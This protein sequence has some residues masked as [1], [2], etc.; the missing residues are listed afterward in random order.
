MPEFPLK[1]TKKNM[2]EFRKSNK[3]KKEKIIRGK[4]NEPKVSTGPK[5]SPRPVPPPSV[6]F[7]FIEK[8]DR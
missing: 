4:L 5:F 2:P 1:K 7:F 3:R 6:Y 8:P